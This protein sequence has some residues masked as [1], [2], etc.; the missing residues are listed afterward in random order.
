MSGDPAPASPAAGEWRESVRTLASELLRQ[1]Y[2]PA[3]AR[4]RP[5]RYDNPGSLR[6]RP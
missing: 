2:T 6:A 3:A 1:R 4:F 5:Q